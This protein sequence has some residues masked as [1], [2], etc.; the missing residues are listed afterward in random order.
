M[1]ANSI[2]DRENINDAAVSALQPLPAGVGPG[3]IVDA[4]GARWRVEQVVPR[5][6]CCE[7]HLAGETR[8]SRQ[9]LLWP[10]DRPSAIERRTRFR[11]VRLRT[12]WRSIGALASRQIGPLVPRARLVRADVLPY[13]LEPAIAM[14]AGALRIVLADEVGLGKTVQAG[15]IVADLVERERDARVL[16]VVPAG[17]KR[18]WAAELA[19]LFDIH[20]AMVDAAWLRAAIAD[21]PADVSPWAAPGVYLASTDLVKR[22]DVAT[23][24]ASHVWDLLIVDEVHA[25]AAPT[26]RHGALSLIAARGRRVVSITATP[27][28][29]DAAAF[30]SVVA[31][32]RTPGSPPPI[33][34]RRS[35]ED[36][37]D[38]RRRRH[39]FATVAIGRREFRLQRLLERYCRDV[40]QEAAGDVGGARL[41]VTIL[42]KRALSS[43][44]AAERSLRRRLSLIE[45]IA[46]VPRQL[47]LFDDEEPADD[48]LP[49]SALAA[50]GFSDLNRERKW[51]STLIDASV[52]A[53]AHD[54]KLR[55]LLR[56]LRRTRS[57]ATIVFTEYRDTLRHLADSIPDALHLHGGMSAFERSAVQRTFNE[58]GG[59][60][61]ATDAA[62]EGLNLQQRCRLVV[63]Y[64][65]P[66]NPARLEQRIG[67]VDRIGQQRSVHAITLVA[68]DTAEDLVVANL[69]RRLGRV[70]ATLGERDRLAALL[71][72]TRVARSVIGGEDQNAG[73]KD[74]A[75]DGDR[76]CNEG[77][78]HATALP[79]DVRAEAAAAATQL[80][81]RSAAAQPSARSLISSVRASRALAGGCAIVVRTVAQT[82][83]GVEVAQRCAIV[84]V[85]R[86]IVK[87]RAARDARRAA[88]VGAEAI[89]ARLD[90]CVP[91]LQ[92]WFH[93]TVRV[94]A[95][96]IDARIQR[97]TALRDRRADT[98]PVQRG[99]FDRR[100]LFAA[101]RQSELER[102]LH[103]QH[104]E[105]LLA[106]E[107]ERTLQLSATPA[108]VLIVWR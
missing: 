32:G 95:A 44:A 28:S 4:R 53:R 87:P 79:P 106:L 33:M 9:V 85:P 93:E 81:A 82:S 90:E 57:D 56:L 38:T 66:W 31:L 70:A 99:L 5:A 14:A 65:L 36:I 19:S 55:C 76:A 64:E 75:Y 43:P 103:S 13:Q 35:R 26:E 94:H 60:L 59:V 77:E 88:A 96:A 105:R 69:T 24:L 107:R 89:L 30:A 78:L 54:S 3:A 17:L 34:F 20:A 29:G 67:R 22:P 62:S 80:R 45:G 68:R 48:D 42:R 2:E 40:W 15:W 47:P 97:E 37:G 8:A 102:T 46:D 1:P 86:D 7:L 72:D 25:A 50:P 104:T 10:F 91:D 83:A 101:D 6:D 41:A 58:E 39:R 51:L 49:S 100:A 16:I 27:Y 61:L 74:P 52:A 98:A 71:D 11:P 21:I 73:S 12:W 92:P 63:N 18:Q 108:G 84:H 23:S